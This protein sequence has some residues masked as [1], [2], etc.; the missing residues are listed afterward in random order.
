MPKI[1]EETN[2]A[3]VL[4]MPGAEGILAKH[5]VPCL[6]CP[7]AQIEMKQLTVGQICRMYNIDVEKLLKELN[8]IKNQ[9][10]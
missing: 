4:E 6:T 5:K 7:M 2:L 8:K 9:G 10:S 3:E 1:T